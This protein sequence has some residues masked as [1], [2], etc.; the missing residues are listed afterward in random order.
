MKISIITL[1]IF[2][3]VTLASAQ[4]LKPVHPFSNSWV[5]SGEGGLIIGDT[6]FPDT[7]IDYTGRGLL[8]YFLPTSSSSI[9]GMRLLFGAGY[10]AGKGIAST[11]P[12][13]SNID[14]IRTEFY[15]VGLGLT[16]SLSLGKVVQ[17]YLN[18]SVSYFAFNPLDKNGFELPGNANDNYTK[19]DFNFIGE[20]GFRFL[21]SEKI[22]L[23]TSYAYNFIVDDNIDDIIT[24]DQD[25][26]FHS[27]YG[28]VS[29]YF[30]ADNDGDEDGVK[31]SKDMCPNTP[32][33]VSVDEFGCPLD[34]DNDKIAD[35]LD[36]CPETP[37]NVNVDKDGCPV[38][39]DKD[40]IADY[41][42]KCPDSKLNVEVDNYG[43]EKIKVIEETKPEEEEAENVVFDYIAQSSITFLSGKADLLPDQKILL[44]KIIA[45]MEEN[46]KM[47][48][49]II[50]YADNLGSE[51]DNIKLSL[52]RANNV[53]AYL[54]NNGIE[55]EKLQVYGFGSNIPLA[56]NSVEF[57]RALNRRVEI[58]D[59]NKFAERNSFIRTIS[60]NNYEF[61]EEYSV[62][63]LIFTDGKNYCI[64]VS[65]WK[66][67]NKAN[68][69]VAKLIDKGHTAFWIEALSE[70]T[71]NTRYRVRIGYF[72]SLIAAKEYQKR[73]R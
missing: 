32:F 26:R 72:E 10:I 33:N 22:S 2:G 16:Y 59:M 24:N 64:Q 36:L 7:K 17:P 44:N 25:D 4:T 50:G 40:G 42:D 69:E 46:V 35:Y 37:A 71:G 43:C 31:D 60:I 49:A 62:G 29:Y 54:I 52:T 13:Y 6:D 34:S 1:I 5:I 68:E 21:V 53:A 47:K 66:N 73:I 11:S 14:E 63:N 27:F 65:S 38:D 48:W 19:N 57:G 41:L 56:D 20:F 8:E 28:G 18:T 23:N 12:V 15:H 45:N 30:L 55:K 70:V 39:L 9:F 58:I 51:D 3:F 61:S 67:I